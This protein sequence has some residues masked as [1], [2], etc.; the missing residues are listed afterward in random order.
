MIDDR[1]TPDLIAFRI[2]LRPMTT[3]PED[4]EQ[5]RDSDVST[6]SKFKDGKAEKSVQ[7]SWK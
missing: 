6:H 5:E 4:I 7:T 1:L 3:S 2:S